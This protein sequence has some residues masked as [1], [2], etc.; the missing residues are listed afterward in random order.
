MKIVDYLKDRLAFIIINIILFIIV[1]A[2]MIISKFGEGVI[3]FVFTIW[4]LPITTYI[5]MEFIKTKKYYD[6][7]ESICDNLDKKY[8][9]SEV[10]KE[11]DFIEG[12]IVNNILKD[13]NRNMRE[14]IN[15]Y[16]NMQ[17]GYQEYIETWVHEIKTPIASTMLLMENNEDIIPLSMKNEVRK[18]EDYVDQVLYYSR[19]NDVSKDY[20][21]KDFNLG[22]TV[23]NTIKKNASDFI[24]KNISI[25]IDDIDVNVYSDH[26]WVEFIINQIISNSI[27]YST[28]E[29]SKVCIGASKKNNKIILYIEDNGVGISEK[30]ISRV[31]EKGFTG[32]NGRKFAKS[33]GIGL[34]LCKELCNKLGL[35]V[36]LESKEN[37]GTKINIIF[38]IGRDLLKK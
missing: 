29:N 15:E 36:S 22:T 27:K 30:D 20:I 17:V 24:N 31:F 37:I 5:V 9:L 4:F 18:I 14:H 32:E 35:G 38:P 1:L 23:R 21:V 7:L 16:K 26:K 10:I 13:S 25:E 12:K 19:S 34:Y 11:P 2:M 3:G 8:L 6:Q 33:T 28:K